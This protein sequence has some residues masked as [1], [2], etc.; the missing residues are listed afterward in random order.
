MLKK[1]LKVVAAIFIVILLAAVYF[2]YTSQSTRPNNAVV[3]GV[4]YVGVAVS[5]LD[6][7]A[8]VYHESAD[9]REVDQKRLVDDAVINRLLGTENSVVDSRLMR[10]SNAQL[11]FMQF[12]SPSA[13]AQKA[14]VLPVYGPGIAHVCYQVNQ[15]TNTYQYFLEHGASPI[16]HPEMVQLNPKRPVFYAYARDH[17]NIMLEV[18]HVDVE[19]LNLD[20]PP[21]NDYRI[22]HVS[23]A[24]S[25]MDEIVDFYSVLLE[26]KHPRRIGRLMALSGEK[27]DQVSGL[28]NS[29]IAMSWFQTR[30]LELE[31]IQY[32][33]HPTPKTV[34]PRPFDAAGYN[35][36]MFDVTSLEAAKEKLLAAGGTLVTE[37]QTLDDH[38]VLLGRDPDGNLLGFQ[39][40]GL[41]SA[42]SSKHFQDNGI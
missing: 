18:E 3:Q 9:M 42:Y 1:I 27:V 16:G 12:E 7:T 37:G 28:T 4:H 6:K 30:N 13:E 5:D 34:T 14:G 26:E 15:T 31:I 25:N 20:T 8:V 36:I 33:S 39:V 11:R 24:T 17:D 40:I 41:D 10:S 19:A 38:E 35:L 22:R 32:K 29:E 2:W 21:K 23:L